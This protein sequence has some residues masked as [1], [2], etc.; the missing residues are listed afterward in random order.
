MRGIATHA[1]MVL[2]LAFIVGGLLLLPYGTTASAEGTT[3]A[4]IEGYVTAAAQHGGGWVQLVF[5][6]I[7]NQCDAYSITALDFQAL[8]DWLQANAPAGTVV[9]T[10][11]QVIGGPFQ[12]PAAP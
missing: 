9:E 11:A 4:T 3:V 10:T 6:H 1:R 7:C 5:H 12:P 8:L 2:A